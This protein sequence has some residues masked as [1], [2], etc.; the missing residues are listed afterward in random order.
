MPRV[1]LRVV[2]SF[3]FPLLVGMFCT[4]SAN[5][6]TPRSL[7]VEQPL[8]AGMTATAFLL[9][10]EVIFGSPFQKIVTRSV[11]L[12]LAFPPLC[13]RSFLRNPRWSFVPFFSDAFASC[14]CA[15]WP[16]HFFFSRRAFNLSSRVVFFYSPPFTFSSLGV[17]SSPCACPA[18]RES[19]PTPGPAATSPAGLAASLSLFC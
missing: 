1:P 19:A 11:H 5:K 13:Y 16:R 10:N 6:F 2:F 12:S 3:S 15:D 4:W 17:P 7:F 18:P 14:A 9:S 8:G